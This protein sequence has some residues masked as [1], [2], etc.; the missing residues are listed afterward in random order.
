M[1]AGRRQD[2]FSR[3]AR[4]RGGGPG[5][6][7]VALRAA[8]RRPSGTVIALRRSEARGAGVLVVV[9]ARDAAGTVVA[10]IAA[11]TAALPRADVLVVDDGSTDGTGALAR[12]A[13]VR[14][15]SLHVLDRPS[16]A[17]LGDAARDGLRWGLARGYTVLCELDADG[18]DPAELPRLV[19]PILRGEADVV[20]GSRFVAGGE[21]VGAWMT[22]RTVIR[23]GSL[24]ANQVL[25]LGVR[26]P[27]AGM[28]AYAAAQLAR[29]E[30]GA[31]RRDP[32]GFR[33]QLT[34]RA[35][36]ANLLVR[37]LPVCCTERHHRLSGRS[38]T[39]AASALLLVAEL[40]L[41]GWRHP[42]RPAPVAGEGAAGG[43]DVRQLSSGRR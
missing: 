20:L 19:A 15:G 17:G 12:Q 40:R 32:L 4:R 9:P 33:L 14:Q 28:R 7:L 21:T 3:G 8:P 18:Y 35:R 10:T 25:R 39:T 29:L 43:G 31:V 26:D 34:H 36:R 37:E 5:A 22:R 27:S 6:R 42:A 2:W 13:P 41:L 24:A 16:P 30:L 38:A 11:V 23:A 1:T